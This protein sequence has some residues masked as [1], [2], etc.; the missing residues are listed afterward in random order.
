MNGPTTNWEVVEPGRIL[1]VEDDAAVR[2]SLEAIFGTECQVESA[3]SVAG[4][5][6]LLASTRFDAVVTDYALG[7]GTARDVIE[8]AAA[9]CPHLSVILLTGDAGRVDDRSLNPTGRTVFFL[10]PV[11]P[12]AL[13]A[14]VKAEIAGSRAASPR[15]KLAGR[16]NT[17][18][19]GRAGAP[20]S[21]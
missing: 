1:I 7:D 15:R 13:I 10:K 12:N 18:V 11:N 8:S 4:A 21:R 5:K 19:P 17:P 14:R 3:G 16:G 6:A 2:E 20:P 9:S